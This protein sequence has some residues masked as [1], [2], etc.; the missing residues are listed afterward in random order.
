M[1]RGRF[2]ASAGGIDDVVEEGADPISAGL[3]ETTFDEAI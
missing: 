3:R 1:R 2:P